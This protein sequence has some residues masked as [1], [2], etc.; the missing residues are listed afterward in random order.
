VAVDAYFEGQREAAI[1]ERRRASR[2]SAALSAVYPTAVS[3]DAGFQTNSG[4]RTGRMEEVS[5]P[6]V[7]ISLRTTRDPD[8]MENVVMAATCRRSRCSAKRPAYRRTGP[9]Y[10][11]RAFST[12]SATA[13]SAAVRPD[14]RLRRGAALGHA[15]AGVVRSGAA[16]PASTWVIHPRPRAKGDAPPTIPRLQRAI[17]EHRAIYLPSGY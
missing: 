6:A 3:I 11:A 10:E 14:D 13:T 7:V 17:A 2:L 1:R 8:H 9:M 5:G 4:S 12:G 16:P 15:A